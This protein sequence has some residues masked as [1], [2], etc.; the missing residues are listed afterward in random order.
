[1]LELNLKDMSNIFFFATFCT[2]LCLFVLLLCLLFSLLFL[3]PISRFNVSSKMV[4]IF[5]VVFHL[6]SCSSFPAKFIFPGRAETPPKQFTSL[7]LWGRGKIY[8]VDVGI[9]PC[10]RGKGKNFQSRRKIGNR[11]VFFSMRKYFSLFSSK[12]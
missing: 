6:F 1:M 9:L 12:C 5:A 4:D 2:N 3:I 7:F 11:K 8:P 10:S